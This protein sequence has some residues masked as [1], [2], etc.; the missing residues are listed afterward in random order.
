MYKGI[1]TTMDEGQTPIVAQSIHEN[2]RAEVALSDT[3]SSLKGPGGKPGQGHAAVLAFSCK[4]H[5][6]DVG[7]VSPTLRA[8]AHDKSHMNGGGQVAVLTGFSVRRL[9]PIECERLQGFP[10]SYTA[11]GA[12]TPRYKA[13][14]NSWAVPVVRWIGGRIE[15]EWWGSQQ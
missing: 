14:G 15:R 11:H 8:M 1:N 7:D 5:G 6:G 12:D 9:M 2:Q 10:D 3:A 13:L 4:D